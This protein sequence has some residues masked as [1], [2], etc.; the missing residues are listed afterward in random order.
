MSKLR[1][2]N[3]M[4]KPVALK[5]LARHKNHATWRRSSVLLPVAWLPFERMVDGS[6]RD[7]L[8]AGGHFCCPQKGIKVMDSQNVPNNQKVAPVLIE[9]TAKKWKKLQLIGVVLFIVFGVA[10]LVSPNTFTTLLF[11]VSIGIFVWGR[12]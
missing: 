5:L 3:L 8:Q 1:H 12:F 9:Q 6:A 10:L 4:P 11:F 2:Y 7:Y